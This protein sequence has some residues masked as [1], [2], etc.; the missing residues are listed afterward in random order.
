M[1]AYRQESFCRFPKEIGE[2]FIQNIFARTYKTLLS[3]VDRIN[4]HKDQD[5]VILYVGEF[6]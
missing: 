3:R 6:T 1:Y 4:T 5:I 2:I